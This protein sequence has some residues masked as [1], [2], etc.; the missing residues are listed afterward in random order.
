M[1]SPDLVS[2]RV[3]QTNSAIIEGGCE[4]GAGKSLAQKDEVKSVTPGSLP[5]VLKGCR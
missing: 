1:D 3:G 5:S 2:D 4:P